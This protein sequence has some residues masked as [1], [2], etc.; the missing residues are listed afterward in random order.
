MTCAD[1]MAARDWLLENEAGGAGP[2]V[3]AEAWREAAAAAPSRRRSGSGRDSL[4]VPAGLGTASP[5]ARPSSS[6]GLCPSP[7]GRR[8]GGGRRDPVGRC[9]SSV[10]SPGGSGGGGAARGPAG[11]AAAG[12]GAA[13][14]AAIGRGRALPGA[15]AALRAVR[16]RLS[17]AAA[18]WTNP[19]SPYLGEQSAPPL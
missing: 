15:A 3:K 2:G 8:L 11:T 9:L 17:T 19:R 1:M 13:G 6:A 14:T 12:D 7:R 10:L 5:R 4:P 16:E 18:G